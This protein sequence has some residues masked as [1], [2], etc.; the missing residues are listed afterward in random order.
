MEAQQ[1]RE[2]LAGSAAIDENNS[3]AKR[4]A[5][6]MIDG[7]LELKFQELENEKS[8]HDVTKEELRTTKEQLQAMKDLYEPPTP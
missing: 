7:F 4:I 5:I 8:G 1:A 2:I 3:A 6:Q